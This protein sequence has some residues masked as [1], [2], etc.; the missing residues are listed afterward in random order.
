MNYGSR[1]TAV[2]GALICL[3]AGGGGEVPLSFR[4]VS[5]EAGILPHLAGLRGHSGAWGDVDGDGWLDLYVGTFHEEGSK[6]NAFLRS[7]RGKFRLDDQEHLRTSGC[8]SGS[9]FVDFDNDGD[10]DFY[11]SNLSKKGGGPTSTTNLLFRNDGGGRFMDV[12]MAA[13]ASPP[14]FKGRS[15]APLDFDGDGLLDLVVCEDH[16]YGSLKRSR[17]FRNKGGLAFEDVSEAAGLP[18]G[19]AAL[20][21]AVGDVNG[22]GR[23]DFFLAGRET[24]NVLFLND[25]RGKFRE[26]RSLRALFAWTYETGD[27]AACGACFGDVN[28]D[29]L[30]DLVVGQHFK[31]PWMKPVPIRLFLNRGVRNGDPVFEEITEAAG[32]APL[33]MKAPH[34]EIQDLDNDGRPDIYVGIVKFAGGKPHPVI[35]RNL[36]VRDG[37]PRFRD[38]AWAVNDFPTAED[39]AAGNTGQFYKKMLRERKIEYFAPGP[40]GDY[41]NDGR[42]DLLL[43]S[44]WTECGSLLLRNETAGGNWLQVQVE[45]GEGAN[46]MGI[47]A[48]IE[49]RAAGKTD[50]LACREIATGYGYASGQPAIAHFGLGPEEACDLEVILPHGKGKMSRKG[51]KANQR[52]TL[53]P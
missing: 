35:Y 53:K 47:G 36:G 22:D 40:S 5:Q 34:V 46:R 51:V 20:G 13:G 21:V 7:D 32:L 24:A 37:L 25:G 2:L 17:L 15:A 10:L 49:V 6:A 1:T 11:L 30:P 16:S 9:V 12:S 8:A 19:I 28:R 43:V 18:P 38:D 39:K 26:V 45:A 23:P 14:D 29:G 52:I 3:A 4:D 31:R 41:D 44:W 48:R 33:G 50:L 42:L 27:D